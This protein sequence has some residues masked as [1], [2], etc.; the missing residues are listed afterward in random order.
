MRRINNA[1]KFRSS[2]HCCTHG[3]YTT[4][5]LP[6]RRHCQPRHT[7]NI[8]GSQALQCAGYNIIHRLSLRQFLTEDWLYW[9]IIARSIHLVNRNKSRNPGYHESSTNNYPPNSYIT[10]ATAA[11]AALFRC[12][13]DN[14]L[15]ALYLCHSRLFQAGH[16]APAEHRRKD[17]HPQFRPF[18]QNPFET[19]RFE[20]S[21]AEHN[22]YRRFTLPPPPFAHLYLHPCSPTLYNGSQELIATVIQ[23]QHLLTHAQVQYIPHLVR[24]FLRQ[25]N[26]KL[27]LWCVLYHSSR[28]G[29]TGCYLWGKRRADRRQYIRCDKKAVHSFCLLRLAHD[30]GNP[31]VDHYLLNQFQPCRQQRGLRVAAPRLDDTAGDQPST[32]GEHPRELRSHT[33]DEMRDNI[34][35]HQIILSRHACSFGLVQYPLHNRDLVA[36]VIDRS[37]RR[38]ALYRHAAVIDTIDTGGT[39][40]R[41]AQCKYAGTSAH[42]KNAHPW[43]CA[44]LNLYET[45]ARRGMQARTKSHPRVKFQHNLVLL[46][47]VCS[48][49]GPND[50]PLADMRDMKIIL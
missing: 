43:P 10:F 11:S 2:T 38:G 9:A 28:T 49:R 30:E 21:L 47:L 15:P 31:I 40:F 50:Q 29:I 26:I 16:R 4:I 6:H 24:D 20:Q 23:Q 3:T 48:P 7:D 19:R 37:V 36:Q 18:L 17:S 32:R 5:L 8:R 41:R 42:V 45:Y 33:P 34:H 46:R 27:P 35:Q 39:Q 25:R 44:M 13:L 14:A 22:A 12:L 1:K